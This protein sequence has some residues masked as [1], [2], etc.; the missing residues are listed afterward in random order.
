VIGSGYPKVLFATQLK[1]LAGPGGVRCRQHRWRTH[2][3][4]GRE[5]DQ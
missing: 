3:G 5:C 1:A 4:R 2:R